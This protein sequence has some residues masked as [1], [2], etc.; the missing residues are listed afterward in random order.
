MLKHVLYINWLSFGMVDVQ[1]RWAF[2]PILANVDGRATC[3]SSPY[4]IVREVP[5]HLAVDITLS[6]RAFS[7]YWRPI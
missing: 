5:F 2:S 6:A 1:L 3:C 4:I 7:L